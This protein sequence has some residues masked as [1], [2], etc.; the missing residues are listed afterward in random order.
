MQIESCKQVT[1]HSRQFLRNIPFP[2]APGR[3]ISDNCF[4]NVCS[5]RTCVARLSLT[6]PRSP[7]SRAL[8]WRLTGARA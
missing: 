4:E 1:N 6:C 5:E 2:L 3:K 7:L 8:P